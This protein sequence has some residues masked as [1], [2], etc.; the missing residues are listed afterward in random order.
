[1]EGAN[2]EAA[3]SLLDDAVNEGIPDIQEQE[4]ESTVQVESQASDEPSEDQTAQQSKEEEWFY[5][6]ERL[7]TVPK[8][9]AIPFERFQQVIA[10]RNQERDR[11][12]QLEQELQQRQ[13]APSWMNQPPA[14]WQQPAQQPQQESELPSWL[15]PDIA[16][17]H[18]V[19]Y[20]RQNERARRQ[21]EQQSQQ[22]HQFM[23]QQQLEQQ[24]QQL[25]QWVAAARQETPDVDD[26]YYYQ[27]FQ[28][29]LNHQQVHTQAVQL[30][31]RFNQM[32]QPSRPAAP[33]PAPHPTASGG[34]RQSGGS[35]KK[36]DLSTPEG[37]M[38]KMRDLDL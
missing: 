21:S 22:M 30:Q 13:A 6:Q 36:Y 33:A 28:A 17:P 5:T 23:Q 27:G 15:D 31:A 20:V 37:R 38:A 12:T 25:R 4:Q 11:L 9:A 34:A 26:G 1:M 32:K 16:D 19:E 3:A 29:G 10:Q 14:W 35:A 7:A 2:Y 18:L 8:G 24:A